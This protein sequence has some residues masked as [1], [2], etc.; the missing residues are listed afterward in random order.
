M[1]VTITKAKYY[2]T[3]ISSTSP[4][5]HH[6]VQFTERLVGLNLPSHSKLILRTTTILLILR[7]LG[8]SSYV[9]RRALDDG[10]GRAVDDRV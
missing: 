9:H 6:Y 10:G 7:S 8:L 1:M 5:H 3:Q 2:I 4:F